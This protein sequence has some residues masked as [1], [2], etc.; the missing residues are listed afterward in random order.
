LNAALGFY[1]P[2]A[3]KILGLP[4]GYIS[5]N[6]IVSVYHH[7]REKAYDVVH[8]P[9]VK[10]A[11]MHIQAHVA[12]YGKHTEGDESLLEN[13]KIKKS[14]YL[15]SQKDIEKVRMAWG[16]AQEAATVS[17]LCH[18][19]PGLSFFLM[20]VGLM[21]LDPDHLRATWGF[22]AHDLPP[23][24]ATPDGLVFSLT[25]EDTCTDPTL[26]AIEFSKKQLDST[27]FKVVEIK[28][29]CPF[30]SRRKGKPGFQI[31]D[32]G[33][34]ESLD[35]GYVPQLQFHM[36]CAGVDSAF[37]VSRSATKGTN[38]FQMERD[39]DY[40][41]WMLEIIRC[42]YTTYVKKGK[43]PPQNAY[44]HMRLHTQL[45]LKTREL[46]YSCPLYCHIEQN[47]QG[48]DMR[49]FLDSIHS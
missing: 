46:A 20:E 33:P 48:A 25:E 6:K 13:V 49:T 15:N 37:L 4:R 29:V 22:D 19:L 11:E 26:A 38:V 47:I 43:V 24:G 14:R 27:R 45:L 34:R 8:D 41:R 12:S 23:M 3:A 16:S 9:L 1:Q 28:N 40:I 39:D 18:Q 31:R 44:S 30:S 35:C 5:H 21:T 17:L 36:A 42:F 32:R 7:L 2:R 10:D